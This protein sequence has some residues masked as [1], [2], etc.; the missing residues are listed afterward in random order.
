MSKKYEDRP[1]PAEL[2]NLPYDTQAEIYGNKTLIASARRYATHRRR[3]QGTQTAEQVL[4][5]AHG[6]AEFILLARYRTH[7]KD[8]PAWTIEYI[9]PVV[10]LRKRV[11]SEYGVRQVLQRKTDHLKKRVDTQSIQYRQISVEARELTWLFAQIQQAQS[12]E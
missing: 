4:R 9:S 7:G 11:V 6:S 3:L 8:H 10:G 1:L 12:L 5:M 2:A